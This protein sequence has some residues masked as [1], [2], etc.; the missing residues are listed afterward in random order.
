MNNIFLLFFGWFRYH[1]HMVE[2]TML[3][4]KM[5]TLYVRFELSS[6][7]PT[8]FAVKQVQVEAGKERGTI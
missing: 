1:L 4:M 7:V 3:K 2:T 6:P 5:L 8:P